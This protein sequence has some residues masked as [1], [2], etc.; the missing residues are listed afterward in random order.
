MEGILICGVDEAGRGPLAGPVVA[1][2]VILDRSFPS[3]ILKDSKV[4]TAPAREKTAAVIRKQA[5]SWSTGWAWPEEIDH[6]NIHRATLLAMYRAVLSLK[7]RPA[8]VKVDGLY[9][10]FIT[11]PSETYIKG[12]GYIPEIQAASIIA[13]TMRDLWMIRYSR[14]ESQYMFDKHKGYPTKQHRLLIARYGKSSIHRNSF[15]FSVP[16]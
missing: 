5:I 15:K 4:M 2:A 14:I 13:K 1:G 9:A 6:F 16:E 7:I 8:L 3:S 11:I 10:P 12:D